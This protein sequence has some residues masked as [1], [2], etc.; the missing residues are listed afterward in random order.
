MSS[1]DSFRTKRGVATLGDGKLKIEESF[2]GY[3]RSLYHAYWESDV[4]WR[5]VMFV[6]FAFSPVVAIVWLIGSLAAGRFLL[7]AAVLGLIASL[8]IISYIR[9]FRSP[10]RLRFNQI[11][12]VAATRGQKGVTRPRLVLTYREET[13]TYKRRVN[14]PSLYTPHGEATYE[15]AVAAFRERGFNVE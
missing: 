14:L 12:A 15:R 8:W 1:I 4:G 5:K 7:L 3:A 6:C 11:V 9:G 2:R 13:E 10:D